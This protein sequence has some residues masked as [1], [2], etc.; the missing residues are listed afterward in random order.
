MSSDLD[1]RWARYEALARKAPLQ[2]RHDEINAFFE[3]VSEEQA[4]IFTESYCGPISFYM[5]PCH[6]DMEEMDIACLGVP[7]DASAPMRAGARMGPK[8][9]REWSKLRGPVHESWNVVPFELCRVADYGDISFSSPHDVRACVDQISDLYGQFRENNIAT[10]SIGGVHT[11]THPILRGLTAGEPVGLVHIDAHADTYRGPYQGDQYSD[12][13]V[14]LNAVLDRSIDPER[15]IQIG[16]R[17]RSAIFWDFSHESGMRVIPMD[18]FFQLGVDGVLSEIRKVIGDSPYYL[19]VDA[20]GIDSTYLPGTQ[21][22]EP[23]GLTSRE[24]IQIIRGLRG[25]DVIGADFVELCPP[26]DPHDICANLGAALAFEMLCLLS[27][28]QC[29]RLGERRHTKWIS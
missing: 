1:E 25:M 27:E 14:F 7:M 9:I 2:N 13:A 18:E 24:V 23:F 19:T 5:A 10:L 8:S 26:Y 22:P 29:A 11:I 21:L 3:R 16:I 15:T 28:A 12:A 17:G 4:P 20:D 6:Q